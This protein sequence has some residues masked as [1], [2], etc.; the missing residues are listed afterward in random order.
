MSSLT[1]L[2]F[3]PFFDSRPLRKIGFWPLASDL[4]AIDLQLTVY[5][6]S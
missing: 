2:A 6:L 1:L 5:L 3:E 4:L